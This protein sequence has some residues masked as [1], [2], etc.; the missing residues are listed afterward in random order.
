[1]TT[2][3]IHSSPLGALE[4]PGV[5][6]AVEPGEPFTVTDERAATLLDQSELY[7]LAHTPTLVELKAIAEARG[8]T[9]AGTKKADYIAAITAAESNPA[10]LEGEVE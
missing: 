1:M 7:Q 10:T 2:T 6:G 3:L 5:L 4:I 9:V 8:I